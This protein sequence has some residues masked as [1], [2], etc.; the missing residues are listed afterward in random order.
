[1]VNP[2]DAVVKSPEYVATD[3]DIVICPVNTAEIPN[4]GKFL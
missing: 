2:R 1:M 4:K 3:S